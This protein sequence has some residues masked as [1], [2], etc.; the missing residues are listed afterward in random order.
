MQSHGPLPTLII[1]TVIAF[2]FAL[3]LRRMQRGRRLRL[4]W[5]WVAPVL[6]G[7]LTASMFAFNPP[8]PLG[9]LASVA[10]F[11]IG[12]L[13]GWQRAR[14]VRIDIDPVTHQLSQRESPLALLFLFGIVGLRMAL[15]NYGAQEA[16]ALHINVLVITD[17]L[18]ALAFGLVA[19]QRL[20]LYTRARALLAEAR[21]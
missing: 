1:V 12:A 18:L 14:L 21:A 13:L 7:V 8:S 2:V 17:I 3:R 20:M 6:F 19:T 16:A 9:W 15:R 5:L 10:A 4:E 11:A